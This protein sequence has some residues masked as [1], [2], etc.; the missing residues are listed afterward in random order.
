MAIRTMFATRDAGPA[1]GT[2]NWSNYSD[3]ELDT[4]LK[5]ALIAFDPVQRAERLQQA[6]EVLAAN[7]AMVPLYFQMAS[8]A[9][10]ANLTYTPRSD[11]YTFAWEIRPAPQR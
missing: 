11:V 3:P 9:M 10:R 5:T 6:S 7:V 4:V 8:W 1:W 2:L